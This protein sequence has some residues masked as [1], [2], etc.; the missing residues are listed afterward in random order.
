MENSVRSKIYFVLGS[1]MT[2]VIKLHERENLQFSET[3]V[4][5]IAASLLDFILGKLVLPG[6]DTS[7]DGV[8][9]VKANV[10]VFKAREELSRDRASNG[11]VH[12]LVDRGTDVSILFA[13][14][15]DL[16][17]VPGRVV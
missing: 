6:K 8:E 2:C 9:G 10:V 3:G 16:G 12:A 4:G 17:H 11:V 5:V 1:N 15:I 7:R 14:L 13:D